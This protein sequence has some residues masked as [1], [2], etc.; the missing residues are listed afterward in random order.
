MADMQA[1]GMY[2]L[3]SA[4]GLLPLLE[5][6]QILVVYLVFRRFLVFGQLTPILVLC[7]LS[8]GF[9]LLSS[10]FRDVLPVF[11]DDLRNLGEGKVLALELLPC[12]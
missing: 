11:A 9:E 7:L 10:F 4:A 2:I 1:I 12:H 6:L 5:V 3:T 8:L